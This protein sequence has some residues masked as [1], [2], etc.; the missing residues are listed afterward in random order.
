MQ[1]ELKE[2]KEGLRI[3][4]NEL[5]MIPDS[6]VAV[7]LMLKTEKQ[8]LTMLDWILNHMDENPDEDRVLRIAIL[9]S[10]EVQ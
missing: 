9:I 3:G 5:N 7:E 8:I 6:K 1:D 10:E 2:L 4:L